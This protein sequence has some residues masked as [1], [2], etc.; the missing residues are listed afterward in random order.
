VIAFS[1]EEVTVLVSVEYSL[2][3]VEAETVADAPLVK[4]VTVIVS[5]EPDGADTA[6]EP[7][8]VVIDH[9]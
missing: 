6:T 7:A 3:E 9:V 1:A 5:V 2:R 8:D 4:E